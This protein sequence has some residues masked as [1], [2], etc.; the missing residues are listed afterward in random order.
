M[1]KEWRKEQLLLMTQG[2]S[3]LGTSAVKGTMADLGG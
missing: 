1:D 2:H 3:M